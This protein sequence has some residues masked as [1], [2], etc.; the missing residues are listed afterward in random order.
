[1]LYANDAVKHAFA[2]LPRTLRILIHTLSR[3]FKN[4]IRRCANS[5]IKI[6]RTGQKEFNLTPLRVDGC[7]VVA[8]LRAGATVTCVKP[9]WIVFNTCLVHQA[10]S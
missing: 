5:S 2:S 3:S 8:L 6:S 9:R 7:G 10:A 4:A 1:A